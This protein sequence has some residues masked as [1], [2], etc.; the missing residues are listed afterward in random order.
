MAS[1]FGHAVVALTLGKDYA[2]QEN[3]TK[4]LLLGTFCTIFPDADVVMFKFG[5]PYEHFLGHRG[6]SH[7]LVFAGLLGIVITL[8]FYR[9]SSLTSPRGLRLCAFF[10]LCTAS[11]ILLD[12]LTNGGLG[13]AVF[14]PFD[15]Q[16]YFLPW[17][18]IQVSPIGAKRFFS[19][20]G[21]E[22]LK[23]EF[24]WIGLPSLGFLLLSR[25][26]KKSHRKATPVQPNQ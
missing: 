6:F 1:A 22:V 9:R 2:P 11:H 8:L 16:R 17:R 13:V 10:F 26:F 24:L 4:L 5:V 14:A 25:L 19:Q 20:S 12:A 18:T 3:K 23:S 15:N 21:L 7:S